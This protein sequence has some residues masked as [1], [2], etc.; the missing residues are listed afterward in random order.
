MTADNARHFDRS[1]MRDARP[2]TA[3]TL[4]DLIGQIRNI[5]RADDALAD[6]LPVSAAGE[7]Y[8]SEV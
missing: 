7:E 8:K 2:V 4:D 5:M 1:G 6:G 3:R